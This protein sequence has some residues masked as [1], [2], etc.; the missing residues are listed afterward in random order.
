MKRIVL[1]FMAFAIAGALM[2]QKSN[3]AHNIT[4][5]SD[6]NRNK[7]IDNLQELDDSVHVWE[8]TG[9]AALNMNT[10]GLVNWAAGGNST[11]NMLAFVNAS[12]SYYKNHLAWESNVNTEFGESWTENNKHPWQKTNDKFEVSTKF[13]WEFSKQWYLTALGQ[14]K[15]QYANGYDY[16]K[17]D[18]K[19]LSQFLS[20]SYTDIPIGI[21]WKPNRMFSVYVSPL[22][23]RITTCIANDSVLKDTYLDHEYVMS[24]RAEGKSTDSR[25]DLGISFKGM[26]FYDKIKDLTLS[27]TLCLFT[28]YGKK[29]GNFDVDWDVA[30]TYQFLKYLNVTLG[31]QLKYYDSVKMKVK[32]DVVATQ[33][34]QFKI[35]FGLGVAYSF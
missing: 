14:F 35:N 4:V 33:H 21:D 31:T 26:V 34:V 20:P 30:A 10:V 16:S 6:A 8:I 3:T 28:P 18:L 24:R 12:F 5:N 22:S 25:V 29:F 7:A 1:V 13:G 11:F 15:T 27:T 17:D 2:A 19:L 23:G 32:D 9:I